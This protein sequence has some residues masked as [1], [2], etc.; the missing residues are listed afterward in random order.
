MICNEEVLINNE[1]YNK[2]KEKIIRHT[3]KL[4][5]IDK[6]NFKLFLEIYIIKNL[7][8]D[9]DI[10]NYYISN[11]FFISNAYLILLIYLWKW[12]VII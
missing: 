12:N 2:I 1:E 11:N 8:D 5:S 4:H 6:N 9:K 10:E 7:I 3:I